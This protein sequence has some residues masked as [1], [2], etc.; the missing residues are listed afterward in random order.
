MDWKLEDPVM[1][2]GQVDLGFPRLVRNEASEQVTERVTLEGWKSQVL[3]WESHC[4]CLQKLAHDGISEEVSMPL[5][6]QREKALTAAQ[7]G[8]C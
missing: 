1:A 5:V 6:L 8:R 3:T 2:G 7:I 4:H